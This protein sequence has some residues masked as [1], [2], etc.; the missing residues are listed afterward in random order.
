MSVSYFARGDDFT[1]ADIT[2]L[3]GSHPIKTAT[4]SISTNTNGQAALTDYFAATHFVL[5]A[6][7]Q[8]NT[9]TRITPYI[10]AVTGQWWISCRKVSDD[11]K[12]ASTAL[13]VTI[14]YIDLS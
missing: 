1:L 11:S 12:V 5:N 7:T 4:V 8:T 9:T 10:G 2:E 3:V 6:Y 13:D 14:A